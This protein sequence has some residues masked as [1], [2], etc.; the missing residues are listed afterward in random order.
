MPFPRETEAALLYAHL[1]EEPPSVSTQD[2]TRPRAL[3]AVIAGGH[4]K[5]PEDR[6]PSA[7]AMVAAAREALAGD[8]APVE[9]PSAS[10]AEATR[11]PAANGAVRSRFGETLVDPAVVRA[12]PSVEAARPHRELPSWLLKSLAIAIPVLAFVGFLIGRSGGEQQEPARNVAAAG[13]LTLRFTEDW[14]LL[15]DRDPIPGLV[16]TD[17]IA[18]GLADENH[19]AELRAGVAASA[20]GALVLPPSLIARLDELPNA[21]TVRVGDVAAL[22]YRGLRHRELTAS[23]PSTSSP[24]AAAPRRSRA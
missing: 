24:R 12:A 19:P 10:L 11:A 22:R 15:G 20:A 9:V 23:S 3:D 18:L 21:E 14:E 8:T 7:A 1:A 4:V 6:F 13:P 2:Q 5:E 17:P 16:L